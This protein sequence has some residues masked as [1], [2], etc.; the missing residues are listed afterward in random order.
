MV[1]FDGYYDDPRVN[2]VPVLCC[3]W[4]SVKWKLFNEI[5]P[6]SVTDTL[7]RSER[8]LLAG[9]LNG[10]VEKW[11]NFTCPLI[12][13]N[14]LNSYLPHI[15]IICSPILNSEARAL[16]INSERVRKSQKCVFEI[17]FFLLDGT[18][19]FSF[20]TSA[21]WH[22]RKMWFF[23]KLCVVCRL[24]WDWV[25]RVFPFSIIFYFEYRN[26]GICILI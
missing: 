25:S 15:R 13:R 19:C 7:D 11:D 23:S 20:S 26:Y 22:E 8:M 4:L 2:I 21:A 14:L 6:I 5:T 18:Q 10:C 12:F 17:F 9:W 1:S 24:S 3:V 16:S